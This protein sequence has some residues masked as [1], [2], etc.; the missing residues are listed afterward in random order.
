[1]SCL[2]S[3]NVITMLS[4]FGDIAGGESMSK[5]GY[6]I[7]HGPH[8][9]IPSLILLECLRRSDF[10]KKSEVSG[11]GLFRKFRG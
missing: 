6:L 9:D 7:L 10:C 11:F 4:N 3:S 1:M 2:T 5:N 8:D